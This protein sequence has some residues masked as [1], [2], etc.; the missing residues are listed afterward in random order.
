MDSNQN[1]NND[2]GRSNSEVG[3]AKNVAQLQK[4]ITRCELFGAEFN[5]PNDLINM[6]ELKKL[7]QASDNEI[8]FVHEAVG[9]EDVA[10]N[11]RQIEFQKLDSVATRA[12]NILAVIA[13]EPKIVA[14]AKTIL[15]KIRGEAPKPK[16]RENQEGQETNKPNSNSQQSYDKL[17][18]HFTAL[19]ELIKQLPLYE[20]NET[21]LTIAGLSA[22]HAELVLK[23]KNVIN[24]NAQVKK[25]R[26]RRNKILYHPKEG[27]INRAKLVKL[28]VK[29]LYGSSS[30]QYKDVNAI[31]FRTI[32]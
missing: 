7:Y 31:K 18:D 27:L 25:A 6:V 19:I 15:R 8:R 11:E 12:V 4:L 3:H 1:N 17:I 14:D 21:E 10:I 16:T 9:A 29:S 22:F 28:Y 26:I 23:N 2:G 30:P 13:N 5:P 24:A 20:P 32:Q